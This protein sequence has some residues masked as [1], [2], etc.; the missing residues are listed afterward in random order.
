MWEQGLSDHGG[1]SGL[2]P[3]QGRSGC[4]ARQTRDTSYPPALAGSA[5]DPWNENC[6]VAW[7]LCTM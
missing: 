4:A 3:R 2:T 1:E 7:Q 5:G 6:Q